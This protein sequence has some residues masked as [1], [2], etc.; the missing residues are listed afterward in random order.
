MALVKQNHVRRDEM[1]WFFQKQIQENKLAWFPQLHENEDLLMSNAEDQ[2]RHR[3][4]K[5]AKGLVELRGVWVPK[6]FVETIKNVVAS[7]VA[8]LTREVERK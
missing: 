4:R 1:V 8:R 7:E 3:A 5:K 6:A 2:A